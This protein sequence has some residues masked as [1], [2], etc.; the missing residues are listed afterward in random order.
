MDSCESMKGQVQ[1]AFKTVRKLGSD[2]LLSDVQIGISDYTA[3]VILFLVC[4]GMG[5]WGLYSKPKEV[6]K[7]AQEADSSRDYLL[8][9]RQMTALPVGLSIS[10]SFM[11]AVTILGVPAESY[12][13]G[14]MYAWFPIGFFIIAMTTSLIYLPVFYNCGVTSSYEYRGLSYRLLN[15]LVGNF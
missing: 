6:Q 10:V 1:R 14:T 4:L 5:V 7:K 8:G 11:S 13:F 12:R 15:G 3:L 2:R 9:G